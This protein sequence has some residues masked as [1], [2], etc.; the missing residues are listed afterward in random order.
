MG[1]ETGESWRFQVTCANAD[2]VYLVNQVYDIG[3]N[4]L[5]MVSLGDDVWGL[6]LK[7][8]P[9][10]YRISYYTVEDGTIFN[11]GTAGLTSTRIS[12][13]DPRVTVDLMEQTIPA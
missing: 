1:K 6:E 11:G 7:L 10:H 2:S 4:C 3:K 12:Q 9:G 8:I 5:P 13:H